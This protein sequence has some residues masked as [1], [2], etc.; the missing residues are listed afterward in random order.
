MYFGKKVIEEI[1][2]AETV[3][4]SCENEGCNGWM[5]D[6]FAFEQEPICTQCQSTMV[7][8]V[9]TLPL[10]INDHQTKMLRKGTLI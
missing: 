5:R 2:E 4:W 9:K 7:S 6:N 8:S 1:P 3:I 10:V